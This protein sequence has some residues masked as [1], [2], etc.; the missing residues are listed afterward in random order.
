[1]NLF[2]VLGNILDSL[3]QI[4]P[5]MVEKSETYKMDIYQ[6]VCYH[7]IGHSQCFSVFCIDNMA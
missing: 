7:I 4:G 5:I 3:Q 1:M 2:K 6:G